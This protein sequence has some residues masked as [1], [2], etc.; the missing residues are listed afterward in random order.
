LAT[1]SAV[2]SSGA[3]R[4]ARD[5]ADAAARGRYH[6]EDTVQG[7]CRVVFLSVSRALPPFPLPLALYVAL[8]RALSL[9]LACVLARCVCLSG[10]LCVCLSRCLFVSL[11]FCSSVCPSVWEEDTCMSHMGR[12]TH[13]CLLASLSLC[14]SVCPSVCLPVRDVRVCIVCGV[15]STPLTDRLPASVAYAEED[16]CMAHAE[17]DT[18]MPTSKYALHARA[19]THTHTQA[20]RARTHGCP[21]SL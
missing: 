8:A 2:G 18:C 21:H 1:A 13:A 12:R 15:C 16:T 20:A 11:P 17:D 19:R 9:S 6:I 5:G 14:W 10:C 7:M 4:G 3:G